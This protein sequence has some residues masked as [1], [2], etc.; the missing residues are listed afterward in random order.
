MN[1]NPEE[2]EE[3]EEEETTYDDDGY[4]ETTGTWA[5]PDF[6]QDGEL[7]DPDGSN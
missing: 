1:Y 6:G 2:D 5:D 3:E 7:T 4:D